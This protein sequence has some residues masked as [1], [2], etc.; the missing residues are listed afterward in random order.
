MTA[1]MPPKRQKLVWMVFFRLST[2]LLSICG[3]GGEIRLVVSKAAK[4][5]SDSQAERSGIPR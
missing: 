3:K 5:E 1:G 2:L 4:V